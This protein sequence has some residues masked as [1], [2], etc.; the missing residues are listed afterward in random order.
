MRLVRQCCPRPPIKSQLHI[1]WSHP[2]YIDVLV[3]MTTTLTNQQ[4]ETIGN[5]LQRVWMQLRK[6]GKRRP[7][8][9]YIHL[10][11][12]NSGPLYTNH[13]PCISSCINWQS[14]LQPLIKA[15]AILTANTLW[16]STL[17]GAYSA[18]GETNRNH[19]IRA[20]ELA[21][22]QRRLAIWMGHEVLAM[23]CLLFTSYALMQLDCLKSARDVILRVWK[24]ARSTP[25]VK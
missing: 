5:F 13:M 16:L 24:Y 8:H 6:R 20:G 7:M 18:L 25:N 15:R 2:G 14:K 9:Q 11:V 4:L 17:G 23:Q 10:E 12:I 21:L 22:S 3:A 19:A 1:Y